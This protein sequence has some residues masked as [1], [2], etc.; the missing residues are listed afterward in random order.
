MRRHVGAQEGDGTAIL[1]QLAIDLEYLIEEFRRGGSRQTVQK[2]VPTV[3]DAL[4][5]SQ[6]GIKNTKGIERVCGAVGFTELMEKSGA[7]H[8]YLL[9]GILGLWAFDQRTRKKL[10][11]KTG[12]VPRFSFSQTQWAA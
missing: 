2:A 8:G 1:A 5:T 3:I 6:Q 12:A 7:V 10:R 9:C 4:L 11:K